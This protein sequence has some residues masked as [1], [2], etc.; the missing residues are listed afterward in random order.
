LQRFLHP[1]LSHAW[2]AA[3]F[4]LFGGGGAAAAPIALSFQTA[5][6][7]LWGSGNAAII[8]ESR[9]L[10]TSWSTPSSKLGGIVGGVVTTPGI[11]SVQISPEIP[12]QLITPAVPRRLISPSRRICVPF[13]G[14]TRIPAVY[15]PAI[16]AVYSPRIPAV[17]SPAVPAVE[18]D[19]QTGAEVFVS[20]EGTVG[21]EVG[22]FADSGSVDATVDYAVDLAVPTNVAPL[23]FFAPAA[24]Q[25]LLGQSSFATNFPEI[26]LDVDLVFGAKG[27]FNG[28]AC[29]VGAGCASGSTTVGFDPQSFDF[30][31]FNENQNG[32]VLLLGGLEPAGFN[33]GEPTDIVGGLGDITLTL[34]NVDIAGSVSGNLLAGSGQDDLLKIRGDIDAIALAA[35]GLPPLLGQSFDI[36]VLEAGYDLVDVDFG[37]ALTVEQELS[38][39]PTLMVDFTFSE[40]IFVEGFDQKLDFVSAAVNALPRFALDQNQTVEIGT[41]FWL[42]A[43]FFNRTRFGIEAEL[44]LKALAAE[45]SLSFAGVNFPLGELGPLYEDTFRFDIADLPPLFESAFGLGGFNRIL[46]NSFTVSS[47]APP[48]DPGQTPPEEPSLGD[49]V[50]ALVTGSPIEV[51]QFVGRPA[52]PA[53]TFSFDYRFLTDT[54][55]LEVYL[56]ETRIVALSAAAPMAAWQS[57][58]ALL[59]TADFF[60]AL[61]SQPLSFRFDGPGGSTVLIDNVLFPG[62]ENGT[63]D[64]AALTGGLTGWTTVSGGGRAFAVAGGLGLEVPT[65]GSLSLLL[66]GF[67][68]LALLYRRSRRTTGAAAV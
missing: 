45:I 31:S 53:F 7:S 9:F 64:L 16:P 28:R 10:G 60:M 14:C 40:P 59:N 52:D 19:T 43:S 36:G 67:G 50:M 3:A 61:L 54:G 58:T 33:F 15:T 47:V 56:G 25:T 35:F 6:Q 48:P 23:S 13:V 21:F 24:N 26:S 37:P 22:F 55:I 63:F 2:V 34:P 29:V 18:I 49:Y 39:S 46:G 1:A 42:D 5:G 17:W 44:A 32:K 51:S 20:T 12:P 11:P 41:E 66:A 38:L 68:G 30:V 65:P 57:F 27:Q 4:L 62:I 8:D